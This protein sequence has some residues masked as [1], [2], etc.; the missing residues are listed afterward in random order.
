MGVLVGFGRVDELRRDIK[1]RIQYVESMK[2]KS[3]SAW[4]LASSFSSMIGFSSFKISSW[5]VELEMETGSSWIESRGICVMGG[6]GN[7]WEGRMVISARMRISF[8][9]SWRKRR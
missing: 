3:R 8:E 5:V 7:G 2:V 1:G 4:V 9:Y 6:G